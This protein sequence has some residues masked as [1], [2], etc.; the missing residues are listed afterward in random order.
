MKITSTNR[1][2]ALGALACCALATPH[3]AL[4]QPQ[5]PEA[6]APAPKAKKDKKAAKPGKKQGGKMLMPRVVTATEAA[7]GKPLTPELKEQLTQAMRDRDAAVKAANDAY[8]AVFAEKT[9]L[10]PAQVKEIDKPARNG[11]GVGANAP[12]KPKV[13]GKTDMDALTETDGGTETPVTPK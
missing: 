1:W 7:M 11:N 13:E 5:A 12:A 10:T 2:L 9:G 8:Y 6:E 3:F 4:A